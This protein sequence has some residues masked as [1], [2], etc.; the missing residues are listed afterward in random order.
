MRTF[1]FV[2]GVLTVAST[3]VNVG[4]AVASKVKDLT[5]KEEQ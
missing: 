4:Y 1:L 5:K 3:A 2:V